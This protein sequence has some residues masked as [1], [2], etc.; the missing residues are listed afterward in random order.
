MPSSYLGSPLP[1]TYHSWGER[2]PTSPRHPAASCELPLPKA[3]RPPPTPGRVRSHGRGGS[4]SDGG[5][6]DEVPSVR[7][8]LAQTRRDETRVPAPPGPAPRERVG[9]RLDPRGSP[10]RVLWRTFG[11]AHPL[12]LGWRLGERHAAGSGI[13]SRLP[14]PPPGRREPPGRESPR[15]EGRLGPT[16]SQSDQPGR[17]LTGA[18][19]SPFTSST[20]CDRPPP[21]PLRMD[22]IP[23]LR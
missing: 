20:P 1:S 17:P 4:G 14:P 12:P 5:G 23:S 13:F 15:K 21:T 2:G 11:S 9:V 18:C 7:L 22:L 10:S 19:P 3:H 8:T 6:P 16:S